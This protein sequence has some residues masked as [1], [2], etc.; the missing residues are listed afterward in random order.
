MTRTVVR[1]VMGAALVAALAA[2]QQPTGNPRCDRLLDPQQTGIEAHG[3]K[4]R[5]DP[6]FLPQADQT[7][8]PTY[9]ESIRVGWHDPSTKT[10]WMWPDRADDPLLRKVAWH[11]LGHIVFDERD[12]AA[13]AE[14]WADGYSWC[15]ERV[16]G[17]DYV[18]RPVDCRPY[19]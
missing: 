7:R 14:W 8:P 10:I 13:D 5:C 6:T 2:C 1:V 15:R 18:N 19:L 16:A 12:P 4:L 11:E 9:E 3:Y 17:Q